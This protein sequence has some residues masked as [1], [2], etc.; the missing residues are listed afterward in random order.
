MLLTVDFVHLRLPDVVYSLPLSLF[1]VCDI[2]GLFFCWGVLV[3]WQRIDIV[4]VRVIV[5]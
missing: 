4:Y 1:N 3:L 5:V 2:F